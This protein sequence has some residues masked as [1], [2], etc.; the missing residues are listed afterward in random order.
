MQFEIPTPKIRQL[1]RPEYYNNFYFLNDENVPHP[2]SYFVFGSNLKGIHGAGAAKQA[3]MDFGAQL[4]VGEGYTGRSY[5][6]PTKDR[7]LKVL[8]LDT[9]GF[10]IRKF[11][12]ETQKEKNHFYVTPIGCGLAGYEPEDI[13]PMFQGCVNCYFP[14][15]WKIYIY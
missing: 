15:S 14:Y 12:E 9:I 3:R 11:V 1:P 2:N 7:N 4:G 5:A 6:I 10:H 8:D 13:A